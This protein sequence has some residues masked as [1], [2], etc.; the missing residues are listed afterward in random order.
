MADLVIKNGRV[1]TPGG[2]I[3]GG[4]AVESGRI[5]NVG[6]DASLP[7]AKRTIDAEGCFVIPGL[8]DPH[9]HMTS[10][11]DASIEEGIRTNWPVET[12]GAL[13]G[14]VTTFGHFVGIKGN[15][16]LPMAETTIATGEKSSH[17]DFFCHALLTDEGHFREQAELFRRGITSFKLFFNAYTS[18][19]SSTLSWMGPADEGMLFRALEFSREKGYPALTM[20]HCEEAEIFTILED[21]LKKAGRN[22][23]A[24]WTEAHPNYVEYIGITHAIE[25]A[26]AVGAPLYIVHI[27][28]AEGADLVSQARRQGYP[29]WGETCPHYLTH[30]GDMEAEIGA[31]GK[32]NPALKYNRDRERLWRSVREGSITS[33][34]TDAGTGG[35]TTATR[36]K[37]KG[38]HNAVWEHRIGIKG[39]LEHMLPVLMTFGVNTGRISIEDLARVCAE[40]TARTFGLY[41]RKGAILP[42]SDADLVIVDPEKEIAVDD[43]FYHCLCEVSIYRGWKL[44]GMAKTTLVRGEVMMQDYETVG[45]AGHGRYLPCRSY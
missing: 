6:S 12:D 38:K 32:V 40:N 18:K 25:I 15:P 29:V 27:S 8:I 28:T 23:L 43:K 19:G 21:R 10:E 20:A 34:G 39:G 44:R 9:V 22:D 26:R 5:T 33:I 45:K 14:G 36:E 24:A 7:Q 11:E 42:G 31:W 17:V 35:R 2:V 4:V 30:T 1:V 3:Y 37:G 13:H 16:L 41:P